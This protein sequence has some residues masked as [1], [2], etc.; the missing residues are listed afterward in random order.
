MASMNWSMSMSFL[1]TMSAFII[2]N[3][4]RIASSVSLLTLVSFTVLW[5]D[6]PSFDF[7]TSLTSGFCSAS[8]MPTSRTSFFSSGRCS[9]CIASIM[10]RT[11]FE[12]RA[13]ASTSF[14]RPLPDAAP[15]RIPGTSRIWILALRWQSVPGMQVNVVNS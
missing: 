14:P 4:L 15:S 3:S 10:N 8:R 5:I 7:F 9:G 13:M 2:R 6:R 11:R 12:L 1:I